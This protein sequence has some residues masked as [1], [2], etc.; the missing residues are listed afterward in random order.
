M[1][2]FAPKILKKPDTLSKTMKTTVRHNVATVS[3]PD[4]FRMRSQKEDI[5]AA[6]ENCRAGRLLWNSRFGAQGTCQYLKV[7]C[8]KKAHRSEHQSME[9]SIAMLGSFTACTK[10]RLQALPMSRFTKTSKAEQGCKLTARKPN[11]LQARL[12]KQ[13]CQTSA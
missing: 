8:N 7:C 10:Q 3:L 9:V 12:R 1:C 6:N 2:L 13:G 11:N 4:F 5:R